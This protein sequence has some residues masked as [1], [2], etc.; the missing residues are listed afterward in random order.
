MAEN[1]LAPYS[2]PT[3]P[4]KNNTKFIISDNIL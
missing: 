1:E 4:P 3:Q 2:K